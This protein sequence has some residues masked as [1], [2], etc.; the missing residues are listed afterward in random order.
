MR[1]IM[2]LVSG[3]PATGKSTFAT[4]LSS[5]L[6]T[7]LV[8]FDR[9]TKKTLEVSKANCEDE[10]QRRLFACIPYEF[11]LFI[12]E[13][14]MKSSS[15]LIAEYFFCDK[16]KDALDYL[17]SKYQYT[18]ITVHM[19]ATIETAHR[20]FHERGEND[21]SLDGIRPKVI[22]FENFSK[23]VQQ[24]KDFRYGD[25]LI[26]VD[27]ENFNNVSYEEITYQIRNHMKEI[28]NETYL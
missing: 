24:N 15:M 10:E 13:E 8:C 25:R 20:R 7:P 2:I 26:L 23:G 28:K 27:T 16:M 18:T 6:H 21:S 14:I 17:V 19:D 4:W 3:M 9:I 1:N 22:T 12:C 11:F 5:E